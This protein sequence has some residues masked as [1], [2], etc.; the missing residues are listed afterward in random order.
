MGKVAV[1][2][3]R[4]APRMRGWRRQREAAQCEQP[5]SPTHAG[6][7]GRSAYGCGH[8]RCQPS[9]RGGRGYAMAQVGKSY[10]S[11]PHLRE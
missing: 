11:A 4:S 9:A 1:S 3:D 5:V 2:R 6:V 7:E 8:P 10:V